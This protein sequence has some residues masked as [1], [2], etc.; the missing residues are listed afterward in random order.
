[1]MSA[2]N[3]TTAATIQR[4]AGSGPQIVENRNGGNHPID[5]REPQTANSGTSPADEELPPPLTPNEA[6]YI[7]RRLLDVMEWKK[8][9]RVK[10]LRKSLADVPDDDK[11]EFICQY[12]KELRHEQWGVFFVGMCREI[13][14]E[15]L[16]MVRTDLNVP[17]PREE[18]CWLDLLNTIG[19]A[20][21]EDM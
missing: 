13:S 20:G 4:K 11:R 10:C 21:N 3:A 5:A 8:S 14:P 17:F 1:M 16:Q 19:A 9:C 12:R 2:I 6:A 15:T 18:S 7:I